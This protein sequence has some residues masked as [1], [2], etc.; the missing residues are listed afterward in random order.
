MNTQQAYDKWAEQ[1]DSNIN[2]TR[3]LE[4]IAIRNVL[5]HIVNADI[6]EIGCGT[7]KNSEWLQTK[8]ASLMAADLSEQMLAKAKARLTGIDLIQADI[9]R[10]WSFTQ[11]QFDLVT[12]SL[13]LEHINDLDLIFEQAAQKLKPGGQIYIGELHPFKQYNGSKARFEDEQGTTV[14]TCYTHHISDF[15]NH[16]GDHGFS[17]TQLQEWFDDDDKTGIP[18]ILTLLLTKLF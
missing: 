2:P 15:V 17:I 14:L 1:Y 18:R 12:F 11:K 4:A 16:A 9:T 7:G 10:P 13:V 3:D 5:S 8:A 6:L